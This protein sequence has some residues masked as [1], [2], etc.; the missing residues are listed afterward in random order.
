[1]TDSRQVRKRG[2]QPLFRV[3]APDSAL[4]ALAFARRQHLLICL[5]ALVDAK[6]E[7]VGMVVQPMPE[8]VRA[9]AWIEQPSLIRPRLEAV[10]AMYSAFPQGSFVPIP[11]ELLRDVTLRDV[12]AFR[13]Q[14]VSGRHHMREMMG[15]LGLKTFA[16]TGDLAP[17]DEKRLPF[18]EDAV[19]YVT[20]LEEGL[21][22]ADVIASKRNISKR[23]AEGRIARARAHGL[24][25]PA[26]GRVASGALTETAQRLLG[27]LYE[28]HSTEE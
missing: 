9:G 6:R 4:D 19:L 25:S 5:T 11:A 7:V 8:G 10:L 13:Q 3:S 12:M 15:K 2:F 23:T 18:L 24:L 17:D 14:D 22:P 20:A 21:P 1:M 28:E 26:V 16:R 27:S